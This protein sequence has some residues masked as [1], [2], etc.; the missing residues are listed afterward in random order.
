[1]LDLI[2]QEIPEHLREKEIGSYAT[3]VEEGKY[4]KYFTEAERAEKNKEY[5]KRAAEAFRMESEHKEKI[6]ALNQEIKNAKNELNLMLQIVDNGFSNE[7]GKL[8]LFDDQTAGDMFI[9]DGSG[10]LVEKRRLKPEEREFL[11]F[12]KLG[13]DGQ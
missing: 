6:A 3:K 11:N 13:G 10:M 1:M 9:Y 7:E 2:Y 4:K 12:R 5:V 8:Y